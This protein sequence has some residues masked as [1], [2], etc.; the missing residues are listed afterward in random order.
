MSSLRQNVLSSLRIVG[1]KKEIPKNAREEHDIVTN[2]IGEENIV[3]DCASPST[4]RVIE[5]E[6][7][8][9]SK[10]IQISVLLSK[11]QVV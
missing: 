7:G 3:L 1:G 2:A 11:Q 4:S 9:L 8:S 6:N 5:T 10:S